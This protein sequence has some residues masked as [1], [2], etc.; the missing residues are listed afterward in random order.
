[1]FYL[2]IFC[3]RLWEGEGEIEKAHTYR[4]VQ[5]MAYFCKSEVDLSSW[6][7]PFTLFEEVHLC[8]PCIHQ[9]NQDVSFQEFSC[10]HLPSCCRSGRITDPH[11]LVQLYVGPGDWTQILTFA[12][13][14]H[15]PLSHRSNPRIFLMA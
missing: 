9:T 8:L 4:C 1:M 7:L 12:W 15:Y 13:Q 2:F 10:L 3:V 11:D 5:A 6:S 14:G